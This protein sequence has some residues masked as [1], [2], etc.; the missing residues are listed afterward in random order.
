VVARRGRF[1]DEGDGEVGVAEQRCFPCGVERASRCGVKRAGRCD[2]P[3]RFSELQVPMRRVTPKVLTES[4]R[5]LAR[6]GIVTR[7]AYPEIPPRVEYALTELGRSLLEPLAAQ[8][9]WTLAHRDELRAARARY[10]ERSE[11]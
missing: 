10:A 6:D 5:A 7:T 2:G 8:C 11:V 3:R 9:A 4:L 1:V